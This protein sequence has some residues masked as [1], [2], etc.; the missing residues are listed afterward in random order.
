MSQKAR[1]QFEERL[2]PLMDFL[3]AGAVR[4][5]RD[6]NRAEDLVQEACLKGFRAFQKGQKVEHFKAWLYK[7]MVNTY[8]NEYQEE[9][10]AP[11]GP[12]EPSHEVFEK[13]WSQSAEDEFFSA[14]PEEI[15]MKSLDSLPGEFALAV[16]LCDCEGF[17]YEEIGEIM[18]SPVGTVRSRIARG[19]RLLA[20]RLAPHF[21]DLSDRAER[22]QSTPKG[23]RR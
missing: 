16:K 10:K 22:A 21:K 3:Y 11:T 13:S 15:L 4:I 14:L 1:E 18:S 8:I 19:R 17:S 20:S 6:R 9:K 7:I 5:T 23:E 2:L 12:F